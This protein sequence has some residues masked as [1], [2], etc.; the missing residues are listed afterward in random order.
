MAVYY[1]IKTVGFC[2]LPDLRD[3]IQLLWFQVR[4]AK[5]LPRAN[6]L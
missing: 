4:Y 6:Y 2:Q 3:S 5:G 1:P